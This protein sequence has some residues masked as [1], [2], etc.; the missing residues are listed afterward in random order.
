MANQIYTRT[1]EDYNYSREPVVV[2]QN[3]LINYFDNEVAG[4]GNTGNFVRVH[5]NKEKTKYNYIEKEKIVHDKKKPVLVPKDPV[6]TGIV[7]ELGGEFEKIGGS[8][9]SVGGGNQK[10]GSDNQ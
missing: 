8:D 2:V 7:V 10:M 9:E 6:S 4:M 1:V 5:I 3:R